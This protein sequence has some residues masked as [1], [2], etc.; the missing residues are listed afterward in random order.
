[1]NLINWALDVVFWIVIGS[2]STVKALGKD[3]IIL[4]SYQS[5]LN[6]IQNASFFSDRL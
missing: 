5:V 6:H 4:Q 1:M 2:F 3:D